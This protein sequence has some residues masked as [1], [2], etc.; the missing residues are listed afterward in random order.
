MRSCTIGRTSWR[1]G[2]GGPGSSRKRGWES[3]WSARV[4]MVVSLL[5]IL[6]AGGAYVPLDPSFPAERLAWTAGDAGLSVLLTETELAGSVPAGLTVPIL[7]L[8]GESDLSGESTAEPR[9]W[10]VAGNPAYVLY[11]SGSTGRPKAVVVP[12]GALVNL[13]AAMRDRPGMTAAD[14]VLAVTTISFDMAVVDLLLPL[15]VGARVILARR[16]EAADGAALMR[17]IDRWGVDLVQVTPV[18]WQLL[19][20]AEGAYPNGANANHAYPEGVYPVGAYPKGVDPEG[21][22]PKVG[23]GLAPSRVGGGA[24]GEPRT[25]PPTTREGAS[26]SPT[27]GFGRQEPDRQEPGR[28]EPGRQEPG[29][30]E[31]GGQGPGG[32]GFG[33]QGFG[34]QEPGSQGPGRHGLGR[35]R[36]LSGGEALAPDLAAALAAVTRSFWNLYGPTETTVYATA[37]PVD[38]GPGPVSIGRP[39]ANTRA[40]LLDPTGHLTPLG[41]AGHLHVGGVGLARGY[42]NRP[43]LTAEQFVPDPTGAEPGARLYRTGDLARFLTDGRIDSLGRI[44][45][46]VKLRGYRIE[47]GEI[48][49]VLRQ[50]PGVHEAVV[51]LLAGRGGPEDRRLAAGYTAGEGGAPAAARAAAAP[52]ATAA[53]VHGAVA[54]FSADALPQTPSGKVDRR[55]VAALLAAGSRD[56]RRAA[57]R[58]RGAARSGRR[59][60]GGSLGGDPGAGA[61]RGRGQLLHL[62]RPLAPRHPAGLAGAGGVRC[63]AAAAGGLRAPDGRRS[64]AGD[65]QGVRP[66][67]RRTAAD[68]TGRSAERICRCRSPSSGCGSSTSWKAARSTTCRSRCG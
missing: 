12:H 1:T 64:G 67:G 42:F 50:C 18:T 34:S 54:V 40:V 7:V 36:G 35:I 8:D 62:G 23:E 41:S 32:Q 39:I 33:R 15:A 24:G 22:Y 28:Q 11:T 16:E 20:G 27:L 46:Q 51:V 29:R 13:L 37:G 56:R 21:A 30:Q 58:A 31:S 6:K 4:T 5:G 63:R 9:S 47:L 49:A 10:A 52:R 14:T 55:A 26:P 68:R 66:G 38:G 2:C 44:D 17:L 57:G 3:C 19:L 60:A 48:E 53:A 43:D 61:G 25:F 45:H 59:D 65:R